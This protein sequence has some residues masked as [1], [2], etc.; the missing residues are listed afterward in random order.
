MAKR[1]LMPKDD[2]G[3]AIPIMV[4]SGSHDVD[5]T[6]ASVQSSVID[7]EI[8]RICA[9]GSDIRFLTGVDPVAVATSNFLSANA[10]IWYPVKIGDR[11]AILG[12]IANIATA[13]V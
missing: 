6:S 1:K 13:G 9:I 5:G 11:V 10:E 4:L 3:Q 7:G 2:H 12:G 8:V